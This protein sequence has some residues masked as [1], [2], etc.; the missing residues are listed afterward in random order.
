MD[1]D[2]VVIG[3]GAGGLAAALALARA[4][5]RVAIFE[6]HYLPG[7]WTQSFSL[8][9]H[10]FSPGVHYIGELGPGGGMRRIY[11]GLGVSADLSFTELNRDAYEHVVIGKRRF[12]LPAGR[13]PLER[14]LVNWFPDEAAGIR[15][16]LDLVEKMY[17]QVGATPQH[18]GGA[19]PIDPIVF[20]Q[21]MRSLSA[22]HD[23]FFR[24]PALKAIFSI[25]AGDHCM[26][27]SQVAAAVHMSV[28]AHY[29]DGGFY[30]RGGGR[31]I[32]RAFL[33]QL[34][35]H[36]GE[37]HLRAPVARLLLDRDNR[38][39]GVRLHDGREVTAPVVISNADPGVTWGRLVPDSLRTQW[40]RWRIARARW[41]CSAL[42]LFLGVE[43]DLREL[44]LDSGNLWY[45]QTTDV[46]K[47]Y[48][49]A[50]TPS[51]AWTRD[52]PGFYLGCPTLKDPDRRN[53]N[54]HTL[55]MFVFASDAP[56]RKWRDTTPEERPAAYDELK[57]VLQER[58][59]DVLDRVVPGV[60]DAVSFATLGTP[61]TNEWFIGATEGNVYGTR[62]SRFNMGPFGL[63]VKTHLR[64]FYQV[65]A[66]TL[67]HGVYG[68][69]R[70]GLL[71]AEA[72]LGCSRDE[73]LT[74]GGPALRITPAEPSVAVTPDASTRGE[75]LH[76]SVV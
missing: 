46:G 75:A 1:Y 26:P 51:L 57:K 40:I 6:Q 30:P 58:M 45:S 54:K 21:G 11:E 14:R 35:A 2:A 44:G 76:G 5:R 60:R 47:S 36:G 10:R 70:S 31:A 22:V 27:P 39:C 18:Y 52:P 8:E 3:S 65:G 67:C 13:H 74:A 59:L 71:A 68:A 64:G 33:R 69:T 48:R 15:D 38:A 19:P 7:G 49:L 63:P 43:H 32:P 29:L 55:E 34:R 53:D 28:T 66:S 37:I 25:Q 12:D 16:Y 23:R 20:L 41:S 56:F 73:L 72:I 24:D 4:G 17:R 61:L 62:R 9:G 42:S 50:Q